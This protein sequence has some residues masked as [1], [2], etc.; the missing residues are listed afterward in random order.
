VI[1]GLELLKMDLQLI[2]EHW[3]DF[4]YREPP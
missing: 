2:F 1:A 4:D 3:R